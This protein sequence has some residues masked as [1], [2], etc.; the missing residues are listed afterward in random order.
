METSHLDIKQAVDIWSLG[1]VFSEVAVWVVHDKH[2]LYTYRQMRQDETKQ[3]FEFKDGCAFHDGEKV[4]RSVG[5]MH[6]EVLQNIRRSDHVTRSVVEKMITE[7]LDEVDG[8]PNTKQL[9]RKSHQILIDAQTKLIAARGENQ[10]ADSESRRQ[11]PPIIP[12]DL[13]QPQTDQVGRNRLPELWSSHKR[14]RDMR[15]ATFNVAAREYTASAESNANNAYAYETQDQ[16]L[17]T[18]PKMRSSPRDLR[19]ITH[20][21]SQNSLGYTSHHQS[22]QKVQNQKVEEV[23]PRPQRDVDGLQCRLISKTSASTPSSQPLPYLSLV[24]AENWMLRKRAGKA[25]SILK[26]AYLLDNLNDRDHV[27]YASDLTHTF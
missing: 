12:P 9:W 25:T 11:T 6:E 15:A 7:M 1:C 27:C 8:R 14:P 18:T 20:N 4:L 2:R 24:N 19:V 10:M 3:L 21:Q 22:A 23:P 13:P 17:D 16:T 5:I 26:H